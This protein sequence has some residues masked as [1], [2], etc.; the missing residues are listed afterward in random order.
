MKNQDIKPEVK[1]G[2]LQPKAEEPEVK[3]AEGWREEF[4]RHLRVEQGR[5]P[6]TVEAYRR[7]LEAY[8]A[9]ITGGKPEVF[10]PTDIATNDIRVWLA[11]LSR[12]NMT[13][14]TVKRKLQSLRAFFRFLHKRGAI[15]ADP[16][17]PIEMHLRRRRLPT[18]VPAAEM[19]RVLETDSASAS[20]ESFAS[21]RDRLIIE[22]LYTTG[23]RRAEMLALSDGSFR[24]SQGEV[25]IVGKGN[26]ERVVPLAPTV[27][28]HIR[29]YFRVRDEEFPGSAL[30]TQR[31]LISRGRA[32]SRNKLTEIVRRELA[33]TSTEKK[34]PHVLR[35]TFATAM[36]NNGADIETVREFLGHTSLSTTQ[37]YT[38]VTVREML[39]EYGTAHPRNK[40][41]SWK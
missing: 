12:Q 32:M 30:A 16:S 8:A 13:Q 20:T 9:F 10:S 1:P 34:S 21:V 3:P 27:I 7:D 28:A 5:S 14:T 41:S 26:K 38:H 36:L 4:L 19:E 33:G 24:L 39:R 22:L 29:E 2:G 25:R 6:L 15:A 11:E 35:H 37:I 31:F 23:M 17:A 40:K 18:Y